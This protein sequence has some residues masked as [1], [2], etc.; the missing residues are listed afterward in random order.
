MR[1]WF[2]N[3]I[4]AAAAVACISGVDGLGQRRSKYEATLS[5]QSI[6][7]QVSQVY[8]KCC[9]W[10]KCDIWEWNWFTM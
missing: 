9:R 4:A 5:V 10:F 1:Q 7:F 3:G 8:K 6:D 2:Y